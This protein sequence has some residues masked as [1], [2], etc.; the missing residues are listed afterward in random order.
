MLIK[1]G[2]MLGPHLW[3][4]VQSLGQQYVEFIV[5]QIGRETWNN[6]LG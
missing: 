3:T 5:E 2:T 1:K 6:C 4:K